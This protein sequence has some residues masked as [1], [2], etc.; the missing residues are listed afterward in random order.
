MSALSAISIRTKEID[1]LF[2]ATDTVA[3]NRN[4][5]PESYHSIGSKSIYI[6]HLKTNVISF[7][8]TWLAKKI[9]A[10][11]DSARL[12]DDMDKLIFAINLAF[13]DYYKEEA[14]DIS[15]NTD[16]YNDSFIGLIMLSGSSYKKDCTDMFSDNRER[17]LLMVRK[18]VIY[19]DHVKDCGWMNTESDDYN[20]GIISIDHPQLRPEQIEK[21]DQVNKE[22]IESNFIAGSL[23]I[24]KDKL[25]ANRQNYL[26]SGREGMVTAGEIH[27]TILSLS[28]GDTFG[29]GLLVS[30]QIL[31]RFEDYEEV[32]KEIQSNL[33]IGGFLEKNK[34]IQKWD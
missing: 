15:F 23:N 17:S 14:K 1:Y 3:V 2:I 24:I 18:F 28:K 10:F 20:G 5:K 30:Q 29:E 9:H 22:L 6:P 26:D 13:Y 31:H 8:T 4:I 7:G 12:I 34:E 16:D 21:I 11:I 19:K 33:Q 27:G 32:K 25:I